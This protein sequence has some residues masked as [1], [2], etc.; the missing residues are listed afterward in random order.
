[1]S[2]KKA[3]S[4]NFARSAATASF[5]P[6]PPVIASYQSGWKNINFAHYQLP[7]WEIPEIAS[8]QHTIAFSSRQGSGATELVFGNRVSQIPR[9][10]KQ[11]FIGIFPCKLL[12]KCR[13]SEESEFSHIY[14]DSTFLSHAAHESVNPDR[15][16][17]MLTL[18]PTADP[19]IW[20]IGASLKSVLENDPQNSCFYAESMA[21]ALAAHLL[22]FYATSPHVL[23]EYE[24]GLSKV[25]IGQA[26]EYINEHL[27]RN[28]TLTEIA[29][30]VDMSQYYFCRL[31]KQSIG[32]TPHQYLI[33]QRVERSKPLLKQPEAKI[34]DIAT[35]CGFAN[36]SHFAKCFRQRVGISPQQ[37]RSIWRQ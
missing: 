31:F 6:R 37:F 23:R 18:P 33:Q 17:L 22:R 27:D 14:L 1:M 12:M 34:I 29:V 36:P 35:Q 26:I 32:M 21:T 8:P 24:D 16:E 13:W 11:H 5:L 4:V 7:A 10:E 30:E 20:Q 15:V 19:L 25:K 2:N 3:L 9:V 28:L